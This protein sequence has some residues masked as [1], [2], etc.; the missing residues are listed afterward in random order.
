[1]EVN[2]WNYFHGEYFEEKTEGETEGEKGRDRGRDRGETEERQ[3]ETGTG[4]RNR[5]G[6]PHT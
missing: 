6:R 5:V 2:V 3:G 4:G 1:M